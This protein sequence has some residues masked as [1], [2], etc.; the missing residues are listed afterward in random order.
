MRQPVESE[1]PARRSRLVGLLAGAGAPP[2]AVIGV[3]HALERGRGRNAVPAGAA[4]LGSILTVAAL[5]ATAVFGAS[6]THLT[7]TPALYGQSFDT[8]FNIDDTASPAQAEQMLAGIERQRA[9]RDITAGIG[10]DTTINGKIVN[11][12]GGEPLRGQL[13]FTTVD[14]RLPGAVDEVALGA[15]TMR[16]VGA[17]VG[18]TVRVTVT[19]A[20]GTARTSSFQVVGTATFP[21]D[22]GVDGLGTGALFTLE[23]LLGGRCPA[24]PAQ[25]SCEVHAV[26]DMQGAF[27]VRAAPGPQGPAALSALA[28]AWPI[29]VSYPVPPTNLVNFGEAVNFPL[30]F[31]LILIVFGMATLLHVLV[32]SVA[33]RR[34]E[35][36]LLKALGFVRRQVAFS[37][38]WQTTT[39]ALVGII[40]GVPAGIVVGRL[41]WRAFAVNLGVL[42]VTVVIAW[43]V[44]AVAAG[45]LVV[46]NVLAIGPALVASRSRPASLLRS[47]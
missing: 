46:A 13:S 18:S 4:L 25:R 23:G 34:R 31:G 5:C 17:H 24:D 9:I 35:V 41:I 19:G 1:L 3:R 45:T 10:V 14:G 30:L 12:L 28:R 2:S 38:S 37:V 15:T 20:G 6:L 21:P 16:Q 27:L 8:S 40:I 47:E 36:G 39:V 26:I 29:E 32:V 33:R 22:F 42:P 7:S 43:V 44:A 11:A